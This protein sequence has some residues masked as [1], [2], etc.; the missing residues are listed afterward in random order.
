VAEVMPVAFP[1]SIFIPSTFN[2]RRYIAFTSAHM[3]QVIYG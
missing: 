3:K 1:L 2:L